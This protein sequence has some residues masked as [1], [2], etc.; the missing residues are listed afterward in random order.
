MRPVTLS[1]GWGHLYA[2]SPGPFFCSS[3]LG[4]S[5]PVN[6]LPGE[7][8]LFFPLIYSM[9]ELDHVIPKVMSNS[10][11]LKMLVVLR[12]KSQGG[13]WYKAKDK[14][15]LPSGHMSFPC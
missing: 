8:F 10:E 1:S 7:S 11:I 9:M 13:W 2:L 5:S 12:T 14:P 6:S 3:E 15:S 4:N